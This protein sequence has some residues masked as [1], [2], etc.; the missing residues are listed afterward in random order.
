MAGESAAD[1]V[2]FLHLVR[3]EKQLFATG[4]ALKN[5]HGRVDV[6]LGDL[7]VED[8]FHVAGAFE[9]L[10]NQIVG[11]AVGLNERS[12]HDG[13]AAG[14]AGVAGAGEHAPRAFQGTGVH[15]AGEAALAAAV[16]AD[17]VVESAGQSRDGIQQHE[18]MLAGFDEAAGALHGEGGDAN[19]LARIAVVVAGHD[20]GPGYGAGNFRHFLRSLVHEEDDQFD[21]RI[22]VPHSF[23][24]VLEDGRLP[25][26][27]RCYDQSA[28]SATDRRD[29]I[30]EARGV[31]ARIGFEDVAL[32]RIDGCQLFK[33]R[34]QAVGIG[35]AAIHRLDLDDLRP[36]TAATHHGFDPESVAEA[37][38]AHHFR[39]DERISGQ[40]RIIAFT[41]AE[42]AEAFA[43]G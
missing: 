8:Q 21:V 34:Q 28:L 23:R 42:K 38:I 36:A 37:K 3:R 26:T 15:T 24:D 39:G 11:A 10:E 43:G 6:L 27:R 40:R 25:R 5:V 31:A 14:F 17:G 13:E 2:D 4:A 20:F 18:D 12:A 19:V 29:E 9:F 22:V 32:R 35:G 33:E 41:G 7:A 1:D 30:N 16:A